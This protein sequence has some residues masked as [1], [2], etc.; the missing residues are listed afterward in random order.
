MYNSTLHKPPLQSH[1]TPDLFWWEFSLSPIFTDLI[2]H[3][4]WSNRSA[5]MTKC[6]TDFHHQHRI[7]CGESQTSFT[8]N[9]T[10]PASKEGQLFSR[11]I[12][13]QEE[14]SL[15]WSTGNYFSHVL[16][17]NLPT[18]EKRPKVYILYLKTRIST[19]EAH[20]FSLF[21]ASFHPFSLKFG[22]NVAW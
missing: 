3:Y 11:A 15:Y 5:L 20:V 18:P 22:K 12:S 6:W 13:T 1:Q 10:R 9:A 21:T 7:F 2:I 8:Q 14:P 16:R 19:N 4:Y 17:C